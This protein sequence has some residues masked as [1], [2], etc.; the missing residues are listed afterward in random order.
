[1]NKSEQTNELFTALAKAQAEIEGAVKDST[2]P[3]FRSKYADLSSVMQACKTPLS[4]HGLSV[5]Q[6]PDSDDPEVVAVTTVLGHTSGQWISSRIVMRPTKSDPQ[7][8]GSA[9]TY[10]R[11]YALAAM[12]G[13][14]PEDDDGNIASA[15]KEAESPVLGRVIK[16]IEGADEVGMYALSKE[17]EQG[18]RA[19][20]GRLNM[21]QKAACRDLEQKGSMMIIDW[22]EYL[23]EAKDKDDHDDA[24]AFLADI[25]DPMQKRLLWAAMDIE[26][27]DFVK[28][29][30]AVA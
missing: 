16:L 17:D 11:R 27:Q 28:R 19:A 6:L 23:K 24:A 10:C 13:V 8:V 25:V 22:A 29:L 12:V 1:M 30:K 21:K 3:H 20:F 14:C 9:L 18:F 15:P 26:T 7:G 5:A 4:K 2:N